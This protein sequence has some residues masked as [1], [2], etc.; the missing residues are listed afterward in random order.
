MSQKPF[1]VEIGYEIIS[2]EGD[3]QYLRGT[4]DPSQ[5]PGVPAP[6]SSQFNRDV[7]GLGNQAEVW[8]KFGPNDVDWDKMALGANA[9]VIGTAE[10][11]DYTDGLFTDF[12]DTTPTGTAVDRFNE[13]LAKLA[14][15]PAPSLVNIDGNTNGSTAKLSFG[16][17]NA[18][19]GYANVDGTGASS[20]LDINDI[21]NLSGNVKGVINASTNVSG[22]LAESTTAHTDGSY[23]ANSFGDGNLGTLKLEVNGTVIHTTDLTTAG[24]GANTNANGSGF[25]LSAPTPVLFAAGGTFDQFQ[26]RT[27]SWLV[28]QADLRLGYNYIRVSHD[29]GG[30]DSWTNY[31]D[32]VVDGDGTTMSAAGGSLAAPTMAGSKFLSGV[33]YHTS[34]SSTYATTIQNIHRD[35]YSHSSSAL[36]FSTSNCSVSSRGLGNISDESDTEV[37]SEAVTVSTGRLLNATISVGVNAQHP[38]KSNLSNQDNQSQSGILL[39]SVPDTASAV[40][41]NMD[42]EAYRLESVSNGA[43]N[44]YNVQANIAT[45]SWDSAEELGVNVGYDDGLL[46]YDGTLRYPTNGLD[47]GDFRNVADG[48]TNGPQYGPASNPDYSSQTGNKVYYR[49]FINNTGQTKANFNLNITGSS[50]GFKSVSGGPSGNDVNVEV[51]FPDG[52]ITTGTGWLDAY[53]NFATNQWAD[54]NGARN[55]T[56]GVGRALNTNWGIT[57]GTKSIAA[58]EAVIVRI[59]AGQSWNGN[60]NDIDLTWL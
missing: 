10:D 58:G 24:A 60:I 55:A 26:Y 57:V 46:I 39:D 41:E 7:D 40:N 42:D 49:Q 8:L 15:P 44:N 3:T 14:P 27:G 29:T 48:N 51:K 30:G 56:T 18:I 4:V 43:V 32:Y 17:S 1:S 37:L 54:G 5:A 23:P 33:E 16:A 20:A 34:G 35:C 52:A 47:N 59:T 13:V 21:F 25:N 45:G 36:S 31:V 50:T 19:A 12:N 22:T 38:I 6:V 9:G 11:G 2:D 53:E 28:N